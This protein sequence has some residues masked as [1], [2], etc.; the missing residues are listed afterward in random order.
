MQLSIHTNNPAALKNYKQ[1]STLLIVKIFFWL[2]LLLQVGCVKLSVSCNV[3]KV[4][5]IASA[6]E[7]CKE[8]PNMAISKEF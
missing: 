2:F 7:D 8:N 4:E 1:A 5:E 6:V 3:D